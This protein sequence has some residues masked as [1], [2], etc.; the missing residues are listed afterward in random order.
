MVLLSEL[1]YTEKAHVR[2]VKVLQRIF[3]QPMRD[4]TWISA[5]FVHELFPNID[6]LVELHCESPHILVIS[7]FPILSILSRVLWWF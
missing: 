1:F 4:E 5:D 3:Y 2:I 7:F 6:E